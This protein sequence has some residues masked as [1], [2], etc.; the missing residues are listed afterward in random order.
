MGASP[1][2]TLHAALPRSM[3]LPGDYRSFAAFEGASVCYSPYT[4]LAYLSQSGAPGDYRSFAAFEGA[5]V[6]YSPYT[7][8]AYLSRAAA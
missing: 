7:P 5:G 4:P 1:D 6:C 2:D 3:A 8:L